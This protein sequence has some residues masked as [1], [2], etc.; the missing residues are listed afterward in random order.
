MIEQIDANDPLAGAT[1]QHIGK[2]KFYTWRG[3][4]AVGFMTDVAGV[5]WILAESWWPFQRKTFVTPP[6]AGFISGHSTYSRAA[7]EALT[8]VTGDPFFPGGMAEYHVPANSN[9]LGVEKGPSVD[10]T[11]QWATYRDASDQ[12]S[13]SRI[14]GSIHP[15]VDDIPGRIVGEKCGVGSYYL[16]KDLFYNDNDSDGFYS[17]EDCNDNNPAI[18]PEQQIFVMGSTT[19]AMDRWTT[20]S[21]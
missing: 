11:L 15:P 7:A 20:T 9:F 19:I 6:F 3:P 5:G 21:P 12:T 2:I 17:Y 16:A 18:Y 14:W 13:L 10:V 1:G 8:L 4:L